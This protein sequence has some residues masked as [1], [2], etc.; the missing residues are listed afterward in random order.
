[1]N[2]VQ[3]PKFAVWLL[4]HCYGEQQEALAGDLVET[5][6]EGRSRRWFWRQTFI[7]LGA[8]MWPQF[9]YAIA[10]V[11]TPVLFVPGVMRRAAAT[12]P[13]W[14]LPW[15]FSML[16]FDLGQSLLATLPA[17]AVLAVA[18]VV[19]GRFSRRSL[20]RT[21]MFSAAVIGLAH[22][23]GAAI[24]NHP[25]APRGAPGP[26]VAMLA[27]LLYFASLLGASHIGCNRPASRRRL[28]A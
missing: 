19:S 17:L 24:A 8:R 22:Y 3:P 12:L 6:A 18:L 7:A 27:A 11:V 13:W 16:V 4:R 21:A 9:C 1:M 5:F 15:P 26:G 20:L 25:S 2:R 23:G 28:P 14:N 10:G